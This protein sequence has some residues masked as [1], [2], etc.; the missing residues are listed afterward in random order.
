[1]TYI[2]MVL[3]EWNVQCIRDIL[4]AII[5]SKTIPYTWNSLAK[6]YGCSSSHQLPTRRRLVQRRRHSP[7]SRSRFRDRH[8][9]WPL[10][11]LYGS[12]HFCVRHSSMPCPFPADPEQCS[13]GYCSRRCHGGAP[14]LCMLG[15]SCQVGVG[16][17]R[18][19]I[20]QCCVVLDKCGGDGGLC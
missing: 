9:S 4:W 7:V 6:S 18:G 16:E 20:G 5:W 8:R 15:S 1:M 14:L 2:I 17:P 3:L 12:Q 10:R 13:S 19:S 11:P